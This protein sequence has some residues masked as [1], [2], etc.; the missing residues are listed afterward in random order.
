MHPGLQLLQLME[1]CRQGSH[2]IHVLLTHLANIPEQV[3]LTH[4]PWVLIY[5][6]GRV[7]HYS[8][9]S[10][11]FETIFLLINFY[12]HPMLL[13]LVLPERQCIHYWRLSAQLFV[14]VQR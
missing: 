6:L 10:A 4:R 14:I 8:V 12:R 9:L 2:A 1:L 3:Q 5:A 13:L 7:W 11:L